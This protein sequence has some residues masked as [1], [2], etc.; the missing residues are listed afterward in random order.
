ML[1]KAHNPESVMNLQALFIGAFCLPTGLGMLVFPRRKRLI[2]EAKVTR[3]KE[4]L[5]VGAAE[6]FFEEGRSLV[7]YPLP[8]TDLKWRIK[9]AFLTACGIVLLVLGYVH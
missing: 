3:R 9:G 4:Q 6:R 1:G 7:A 2:T 8:A 5:A